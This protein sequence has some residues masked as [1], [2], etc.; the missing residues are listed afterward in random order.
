[1]EWPIICQGRSVTQEDVDFLRLWIEGFVPV[2]YVSRS[3]AWPFPKLPDD[4]LY[5]FL[6]TPAEGVLFIE[7]LNLFSSI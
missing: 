5:T 7:A 3:V 6:K 1:M 2:C 4:F